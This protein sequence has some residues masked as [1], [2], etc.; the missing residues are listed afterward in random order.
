MTGWELASVLYEFQINE[1]APRARQGS[2]NGRITKGSGKKIG[3]QRVRSD[4][5]NK[6][7]ENSHE[8]R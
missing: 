2:K 7:F 6:M 1:K 5:K 8:D 4:K 3:S